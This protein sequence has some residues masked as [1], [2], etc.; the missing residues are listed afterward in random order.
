MELLALNKVF[1]DTDLD[2]TGNEVQLSIIAPTWEVLGRSKIILDGKSGEKHT[3][4]KS[5][6]GN[7]PGRHGDDGLPGRPGGPAGSFFGIGKQF[8]NDDLLL[9]SANGGNGG[10]GQDGG[11]G[12][13]GADASEAL[14]TKNE[15]IYVVYNEITQWIPGQEGG[16]GGNGGV[17]GIGGYEGNI[18]IIEVGADT[19]KIEAKTLALP[20]NPGEGGEGGS[21]GRGGRYNERSSTNLLFVV[22]LDKT[23]R[24]DKW[25]NNGTNGEAAINSIGIQRTWKTNES[26]YAYNVISRFINYIRENIKEN[27]KEAELSGFLKETNNNER[28]VGLYSTLALVNEMKDLEYKFDR[29]KDKTSLLPFYKSLLQ[30]ITLYSKTPRDSERSEQ[31]IKVLSSL[32]AAVLSKVSNINNNLYPE[33]IIDITGYLESLV[34]NIDKSKEL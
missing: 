21:G 13:D 1:I 15:N 31:Y 4:S 20:G 11:D 19:R 12:S 29:E 16:D 14:Q 17:G 9:I 32:Y 26:L 18:T 2:L 5:A 27:I 8:I 23:E 33:L 24:V 7:R 3:P 10:R 28:I 25:A 6:S 22:N 30:R 34:F